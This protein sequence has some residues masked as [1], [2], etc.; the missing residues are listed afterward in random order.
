MLERRTCERF[1]I[2]GSTIAYTL[3]GFFK[4]QQPFPDKFYPVTD[5]SK[6]GISFLSDIPLRE[7][8]ELSVLLN[9]SEKDSPLQLEGKVAYISLDSGVSY[10]YRIGIQFKPFGTK[11]GLNSL[12]NLNHL[13]ELEKTYSS[14]RKQ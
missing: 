3:H 9:I 10:R 6:G 4:K 1:V 5:L 13:E 11:E 8:K 7:N 12:D 2:P 14:G